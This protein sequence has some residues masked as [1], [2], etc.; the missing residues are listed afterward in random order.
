MTEIKNDIQYDKTIQANKDM[1]EVFN[2]MHEAIVLMDDK[3]RILRLNRAM[4]KLAKIDNIQDVLGQNCFELFNNDKFPCDRA[5]IERV[6]ETESPAVTEI[7]LESDSRTKYYSVSV[8]PISSDNTTKFVYILRN[9]TYEKE[10]FIRQ[11]R[12]ESL[13]AI[14]RLAGA[15]SH[16][17]NQPLGVIVG[18]SQLIKFALTHQ[19]NVDKEEI[20]NDLNEIIQQTA[21]IE[22]ILKRMYTI[23]TVET[24]PYAGNLKI[25]DFEKSSVIGRKES[26]QLDNESK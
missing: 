5:L 17:I 1:A 14:A 3:C 25:V 11:K 26:D 16:E 13:T 7:S 23:D 12:K 8:F 2:L 15:S 6:I 18:R 24:K 21:R 4:K 20:M 9:I 22:K 19:E 10:D